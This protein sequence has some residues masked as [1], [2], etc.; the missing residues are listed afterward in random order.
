MINFQQKTKI[1]ANG[2]KFEVKISPRFV[3]AEVNFTH[4]TDYTPQT[5]T[6]T[7]GTTTTS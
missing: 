5:T 2:K 3:L 4:S 1:D 6:S 7:T